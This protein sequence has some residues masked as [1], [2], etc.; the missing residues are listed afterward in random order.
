MVI[1]NHPFFISSWYS[2][3]TCTKYVYEIME[4]F[5]KKMEIVLVMFTCNCKIS[6]N[7]LLLMCGTVSS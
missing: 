5:C 6:V 3:S 4:L 2:N 1:L 7:G